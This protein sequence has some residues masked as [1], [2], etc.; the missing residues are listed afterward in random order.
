[1]I[2]LQNQGHNVIGIDFSDGLLEIC[3]EKKLNVKKS[4]ITN[5][6]FKDCTFDYVISIA[7]IH[8]IN[9]EDDRIK[10]ISEL[11]LVT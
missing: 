1:M 2:Y 11:L 10:A 7:V 8:H 4:D 6:P 5:L 3:K 9:S